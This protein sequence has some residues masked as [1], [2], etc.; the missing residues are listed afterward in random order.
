SAQSRGGG[1]QVLAANVDVVFVVASLGGELDQNRLDR[2]LTVAWD[3]GAQP[4]V[5]L[6]KADLA[7][8]AAAAVAAVEAQAPLL[9]ASGVTGDGVDELRALLGSGRTA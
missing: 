8:D 6:T 5:V 7:P 9:V 4:V 1:T 3:S 2:Y